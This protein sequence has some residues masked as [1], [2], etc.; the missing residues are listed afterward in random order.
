MGLLPPVP[1]ATRTPGLI[2]VSQPPRPQRSGGIFS[3]RC[4]SWILVLLLLWRRC[5]HTQPRRCYS[6]GA[7]T[8]RR[9]ATARMRPTPVRPPP[10]LARLLGLNSQPMKVR[11]SPLLMAWIERRQGRGEVGRGA[12]WMFG[13]SEEA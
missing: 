2:P 4:G 6:R 8:F 12:G 7:L 3:G 13:K 5:L 1:T 10:P 11:E 9:L